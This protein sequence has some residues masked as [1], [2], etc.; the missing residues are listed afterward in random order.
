M[1][2]TPPPLDVTAPPVTQEEFVDLVC[3]DEELLRATPVRR[4]AD[5]PGRGD[6]R[7]TGFR[8]V[9][10]TDPSTDPSGGSA[11]PREAPVMHL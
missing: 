2:A 4:W 3:A 6:G 5:D 7:L 8:A 9:D 1:R 10:P 11:L